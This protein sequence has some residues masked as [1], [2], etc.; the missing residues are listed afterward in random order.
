MMLK[1]LSRVGKIILFRFW[2]AFLCVE[3]SPATFLPI[4]G[5]WYATWF[6]HKTGKMCADDVGWE[7][8]VEWLLKRW[9]LKLQ[10]AAQDHICVAVADK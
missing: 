6:A 10:I 5:P 3:G 1:G 7:R 2:T 8:S 9:L 4:R